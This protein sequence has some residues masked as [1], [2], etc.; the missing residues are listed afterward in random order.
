MS[1]GGASVT[2]IYCGNLPPDIRRGDVEDLF[3]K[4]GHIGFID[5]KSGR[6]G[7]PFAFI[8]FEDSRFKY[9]H[10]SLLLY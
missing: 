8:E 10:F 2:R 4:F 3:D 1:R 7:P 5:L 9:F 6:S